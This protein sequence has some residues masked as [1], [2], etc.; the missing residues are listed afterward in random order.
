M[1][2]RPKGWSEFDKLARRVVTVPKEAVNAKIV[3]EKATRRKRKS[4]RVINVPGGL[5]D[6]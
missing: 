6:Y 1:I 3:S 5:D 2:Y 4:K